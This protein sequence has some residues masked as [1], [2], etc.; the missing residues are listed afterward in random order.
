M[1]LYKIVLSLH[2]LL[3]VLALVTF[4]VAGMTRKGSSVHRAAG[5]V[6]LAAMVVLLASAV[7]LAI[8]ILVTKSLVAGSFLLYLEVITVTSVWLSWRAIRDKRDW[9]RYSGQAY[10]AL[11]WLNIASGL[12]ILV[13][14]LVAGGG[15]RFI[16]VGF[17]LIGLL[18]GRAMLR[19]ARTAPTGPKWWLKE[20]FGAM[21]G[22]GVATHIAFLSIGLPKLL[23]SLAGPVMHNAA[24]LGPLALAVVARWWL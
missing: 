7:P 5:K 16:L 24:W 23:P 3:G 20:H 11:A 21:L 22:N 6:Y 14:G 18:G 19:F 17:S 2:G 4:W 13:L 12:A 8:R 1:S 10:R 15:L 9:A